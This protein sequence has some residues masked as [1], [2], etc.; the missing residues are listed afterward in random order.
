MEKSK[1]MGG[2]IPAPAL[3]CASQI[4]NRLAWDWNWA[5]YWHMGQ[6]KYN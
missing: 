6:A 4:P 3:L 5:D 1:Y 2:K